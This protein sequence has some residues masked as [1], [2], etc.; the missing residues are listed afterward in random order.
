MNCCAAQFV[1]DLLS[2]FTEVNRKLLGRISHPLVLCCF[3]DDSLTV[4]S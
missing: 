1:E 3:M 2:V 4:K